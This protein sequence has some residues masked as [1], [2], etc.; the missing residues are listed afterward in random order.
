MHIAI[1]W[2]KGIEPGGVVLLGGK[3]S[4]AGS[5]SKSAALPALTAKLGEGEGG[6]AFASMAAARKDGLALLLAQ[7]LECLLC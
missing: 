7:I 4:L 2:D 5:A 1:V 3:G 6:V